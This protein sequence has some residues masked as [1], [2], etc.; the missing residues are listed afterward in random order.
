MPEIIEKSP[1][2]YCLDG[3]S[4]IEGKELERSANLT[5]PEQFEL[6]GEA[7]IYSFMKSKY[8]PGKNEMYLRLTLSYQGR[9]RNDLVEIGKAPMYQSRGPNGPE[10]WD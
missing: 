6:V 10:T 4:A 1:R 7:Y 2:E 5:S 8:V 9:F 3:L